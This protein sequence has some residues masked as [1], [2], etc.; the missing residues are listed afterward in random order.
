M[1]SSRYDHDAVLQLLS[2][3]GRQLDPKLPWDPFLIMQPVNLMLALE[4]HRVLLLEAIVLLRRSYLAGSW[5]AVINFLRCF[6]LAIILRS[7]A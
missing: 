3:T 2:I 1:S 7:V 4:T 5:S 6:L